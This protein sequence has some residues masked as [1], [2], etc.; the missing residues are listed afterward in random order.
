MKKNR[1]QDRRRQSHGTNVLL[2]LPFALEV[3]DAGVA[4][5][6]ANRAVDEVLHA[7]GLGRIR[8]ALTMQDLALY[9]DTRRPK[10]L[11]A[12]NTVG[13][14]QCSFQGR[15]VSQ[16]PLDDAR[17]LIGQDPRSR[18]VGVA[19]ERSHR[20]AGRQQVPCDRSTLLAGRAGYQDGLFLLYSHL[21][22]QIAPPE[23]VRAR[24]EVG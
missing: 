1:A 11:N 24:Q 20:P 19:G 15:T 16:I 8:E 2:D 4:F 18:P 23:S 7:G 21:S 5:G 10:Y 14:F 12:I 6:A 9:A 13:A 17:P 22:F 3:C